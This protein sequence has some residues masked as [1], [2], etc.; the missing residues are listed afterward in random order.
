MLT[1]K[2]ELWP[3]GDEERAREIGRMYIANDGTTSVADPRFGDYRVAVCKRGTNAVPREVY[4][5]SDPAQAQY[6][7]DQGAPKATRAARVRGYPRLAYNVWRLIARAVT[8]AFPEELNTRKG[9][10]EAVL[11]AEVLRGLQSLRQLA[12]KGPLPVE[13]EADR[14]AARAW[15]DAALE[16]DAPAAQDASDVEPKR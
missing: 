5:L 7:K 11:D 6:A 16:L 1:V 10:G 14:N 9:R 2:I 3:Y 12:A 13:G 8:G 4:D 15:L